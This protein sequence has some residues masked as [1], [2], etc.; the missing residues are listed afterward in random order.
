MAKSRVKLVDIAQALNVSV[1]LVSSVLSGKSKENRISEGLTKKVIEKANEMGYQANQMARGLRTGKS[2]IIGIVVADIANPY[3]GKMARYIENEASKLGY[4]V[5]FGSSDEDANKLKSIVN[6]FISRQVDGL[7]IVPVNGSEEYLRKLKKQA[8]PFVFIDRY[9][10]N[11][12]AETICTDNFEGG[13]QLTNLLV[14]KGCK[15]I[16]AFVYDTNVTNNI[17]RIKGYEACLINAGMDTDK[18][19]LV[20][21]VGFKHM[22][23]RLESSM[24]LALKNNC[25]AFFFA[26]NALGVHCVKFFNEISK[27]N[28]PEDLKIVSFDNPEAFQVS[29]PSIT[30]YEQPVEQMS[31]RAVK[32]LFQRISNT[33]VGQNRTYLLPGTLIVRNSI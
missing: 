8:I 9:C 1:G 22:E 4:Q 28:I 30:C 16:A 25:D 13:Y 21:E 14:A 10:E 26:N 33:L 3:F 19:P 11:V 12:E 7:I 5:M 27:V 31:A 29:V 20:Y 15:K 2:G 32:V 17:E 18:E 23:Q 24:K 6:L